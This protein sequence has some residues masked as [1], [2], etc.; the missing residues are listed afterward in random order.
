MSKWLKKYKKFLTE[1]VDILSI[2]DREQQADAIFA[3]LKKA[4][5]DA[6]GGHCGEA[7]IA[8]NKVLF[9]DRGKLVAAV[10]KF[11]YEKGHFIGHVAVLFNGFLWDGEGET[12]EEDLRAWGMLDPEDLDYIEEYGDEWTEEAAMEEIII[13]PTEKEV[14][15]FFGSCSLSDKIKQMKK[16]V[17][18]D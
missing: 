5:M 17:L 16:G 4:S 18:D 6:F 15:K 2:K 14:T 9:K 13:Y 10:N 1:K 3:A 12:N 11:M 7:A 8:I